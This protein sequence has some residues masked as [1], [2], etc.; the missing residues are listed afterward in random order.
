M[1]FSHISGST[2]NTGISLAQRWLFD[3]TVCVGGLRDPEKCPAG[4]GVDS[5]PLLPKTV[6]RLLWVL[7]PSRGG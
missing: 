7:T 3:G 1:P 5:S 2:R 4:R 6:L